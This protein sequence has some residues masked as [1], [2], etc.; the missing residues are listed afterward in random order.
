MNSTEIK[1]IEILSLF[2]KETSQ[3]LAFQL[4]TK[5]YQ[6]RIYWHIRKMV[7]HHEDADDLLQETFIKIW[8]NLPNFRGDASLYTWIYRIATNETLTFLKKKN[9]K[10]SISIH[11]HQNIIDHKIGNDPMFDGTEIEKKLHMALSQL[12]EKQKLIFQMKYFEELKYEEIAEILKVSVGSLKASFH[13]A[14]KK[15]EVFIKNE[16]L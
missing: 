14:V 12:P 1:D 6:T 15:I 13:H 3:R 9:K 16:S 11:E 8:Q 2:Q 5:K 4:L 7:F 10:I